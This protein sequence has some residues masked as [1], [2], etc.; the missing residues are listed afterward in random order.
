[1]SKDDVAGAVM[2]HVVGFSGKASSAGMTRILRESALRTS[3]PIHD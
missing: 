1:M 3:R 2:N